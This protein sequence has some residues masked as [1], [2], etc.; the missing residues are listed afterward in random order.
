MPI[1]FVLAGP[2]AAEIGTR[3]TL[4][5]AAAIVV[6]ATALVLT[7]RDVRTLERAAAP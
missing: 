1:G 2:I 6:A 3:A 4:V 5:G 7:L